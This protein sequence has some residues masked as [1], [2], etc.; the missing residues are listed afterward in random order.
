MTCSAVLC[1][2]HAVLKMET[3][4][5]LL[6][7][8]SGQYGKRGGARVQGSSGC[9]RIGGITGS[10]WCAGHCRSTRREGTF[11]WNTEGYITLLPPCMRGLHHHALHPC[12][13]RGAPVYRYL[14]TLVSCYPAANTR[15]SHYID[16]L[17]IIMISASTAGVRFTNIATVF[18]NFFYRLSIWCMISFFT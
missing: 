2:V 1:C 14:L 6:G 3:G 13:R 15:S 18:R 4:W 16:Q 17:Y 9:Q 8:V 12:P 11:S 7:I 5:W 10:D